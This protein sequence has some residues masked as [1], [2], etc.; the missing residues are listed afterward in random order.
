MQPEVGVEVR[1]RGDGLRREGLVLPARRLLRPDH[2]GE[3]VV[4]RDRVHH[5]HVALV[6]GRELERAAV[7]PPVQR[8]DPIVGPEGDAGDAV[9]LEDDLAEIVARIPQ[10]RELERHG[11]D[12]P[13]AAVRDRLPRLLDERCS[14]GARLRG[15][16]ADR[17]AR[18][19]LGVDGLDPA[20]VRPREGLAAAAVEERPVGRD[21][22]DRAGRRDDR[23]GDAEP[24]DV[25]ANGRRDRAE[26]RRTGGSRAGEHARDDDQRRAGQPHTRPAYTSGFSTPMNGRLR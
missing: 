24:R 14:V 3:V 9:A 15:E 25:H 21:R 1:A 4:R 13:R 12:R 23:V 10:Q 16:R 6:V 2:G 26:H 19:Q 17:L 18:R 5:D 11:D 7:G 8:E 22:R 20:H